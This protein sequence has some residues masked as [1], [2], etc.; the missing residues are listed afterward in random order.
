MIAWAKTMG[1]HDSLYILI[2]FFH[3]VRSPGAFCE[4]VGT[5]QAGGR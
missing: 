3:S 4:G 1:E 5:P 2:R